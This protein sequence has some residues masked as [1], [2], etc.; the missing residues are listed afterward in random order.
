MKN[1]KFTYVLLVVVGIIYYNLFVRIKGNLEVEETL[2]QNNQIRNIEL[3]NFKQPESFDL[4][5]Q[6]VDPFL[7]KTNL[8][9]PLDSIR[10]VNNNNQPKP[11]KEKPIVIWPNIKYYGLVR[12]T[13]VKNPRAILSIDGTVF[14]IGA[15]EE[16]Y[17]GILIK[18]ISKENIEVLF[19][20]ETKSFGRK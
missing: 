20:R 6:Y 14:K 8:S 3:S 19:Q 12:N 18:K 4:S 1:K 17:D 11:K 7:K 9:I 2:S 10:K 5:G 16:L 15:N 13:D